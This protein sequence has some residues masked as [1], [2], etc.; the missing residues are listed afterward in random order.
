ME[1]NMEE[2]DKQ[3]AG[4]K[5]HESALDWEEQPIFKDAV[6][7]HVSMPKAMVNELV[8]HPIFQWLHDI[9]QPGMETLHLGATHNRFCH[10]IGVYHLGKQ[11]FLVFEEDRQSATF[12]TLLMCLL[13]RK[14]SVG[15]GVGPSNKRKHLSCQI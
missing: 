14:K 2:I 12:S 11:L 7:D 3:K 6:L 13:C 15:D 9:A 1:E 10:S 8:E 5:M 4:E